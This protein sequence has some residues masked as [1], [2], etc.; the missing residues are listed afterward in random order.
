[1]LTYR[2]TRKHSPGHHQ[3]RSNGFDI[4]V[5]TCN[6]GRPSLSE[7]GRWSER[8]NHLF[9]WWVRGSKHG[10]QKTLLAI[11]V[12]EKWTT[13]NSGSV[14]RSLP[15]EQQP[16]VL[17]SYSIPDKPVWPWCWKQET[18]FWV[19]QTRK[20]KK[21]VKTVLGSCTM[22]TTRLCQAV[23]EALWV[24]R[25][26]TWKSHYLWQIPF[27]VFVLFFVSSWLV[28]WLICKFVP[29]LVALFHVF[30]LMIL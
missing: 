9:V 17:Y 21:K 26:L 22:Q 11:V 23:L 30:G 2:W 25:K 20:K 6:H 1:M 24:L 29:W 19:L 14:P 15:F 13:Y 4:Q 16:L 7:S 28:G 12:K 8:A 10:T 18:W 3:Q 27:L 5:P